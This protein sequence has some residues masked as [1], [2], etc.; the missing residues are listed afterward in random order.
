MVDQAANHRARHRDDSRASPQSAWRCRGRA[1]SDKDRARLCWRRHGAARCGRRPSLAR[2]CRAPGNIYKAGVRAA[3]VSGSAPTALSCTKRPT[4]PASRETPI[5]L[6]LLSTMPQQRPLV[7]LESQSFWRMLLLLSAA[8]DRGMILNRARPTSAP[9]APYLLFAARPRKVSGDKIWLNC[10]E[11]RRYFSGIGTRHSRVRIL[12]PQ[13]ASP[14][15]TRQ[16]VKSA[17]TA[18]TP[19][20]DCSWALG[21]RNMIHLPGNG[22]QRG[23][24]A[25]LHWILPRLAAYVAV[26][27][28][29]GLLFL[30]GA[31]VYALMWPKPVV[32]FG[33]MGP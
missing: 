21:L 22:E 2:R 28:A 24:G 30:A 32:P 23:M 27:V 9:R 16:K 3:G 26:V 8:A 4:S 10:Q 5:V 6:T 29:A 1:C 7:R 11:S 17:R 15:S 12:P 19:T 25:M 13:P 14:V 18:P 33:Q 31:S 20:F